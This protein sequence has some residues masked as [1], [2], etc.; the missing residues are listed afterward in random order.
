[1]NAITF[2]VVGVPKPSGSKRCFALKKAGIYTGRVVVTDDCRKSGDWKSDVRAAATENY[3]GP[4]LT[5]P[6][7]MELTFFFTRPKSHFGSGKNADKLKAGAPEY[8]CGKPDLTKIVRGV[9][10][11]LTSII[12]KDDAQIVRQHVEKCYAEKP[13]VWINI[14]MQKT[15]YPA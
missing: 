6:L 2:F 10:D 3:A 11:A 9:E 14:E 12:W 4:L 7:V 13:G 8:P 1:M 15:D 5:G